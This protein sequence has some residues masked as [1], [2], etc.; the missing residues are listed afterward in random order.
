M[1]TQVKGVVA[2]FL[3][4]SSVRTAQRAE[5]SKSTK[6]TYLSVVRSFHRHTGGKPASA[7]EPGDVEG[8]MLHLAQERYSRSS[9]KQALCALVYVFRHVLGRD[10]GTL[11]LP[12]MPK[13]RRPAKI[14]PTRDELRVLFSHL[15]G[16]VRTMCGVMYG[17]GLRVGEC[18]QLRVK[19][20]DFS[21]LTIRVHEGK[22]DK[23]RLCLLPVALAPALQRQIEWRAAMHAQDVAEGAGWVELPGRLAKK[24]PAAPR[25]LRWQFLFPSAVLRGGH[26]WHATPEAVQKALRAAVLRAGILKL[27]TPHT[28]R[29]AFCTHALRAGNDAATVQELMG[30]DSLE[31]TMTYAHGDHARGVSPLDAA[32]VVPLMTYAHGDH[33]RGV[34]P[35]D[36]ADVVPLMTPMLR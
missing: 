29:H 13:E 31:T 12:A 18:C 24:Y 10:L 28:L 23:D 25:D 14:I 3:E 19:D 5:L 4:V 11:D 26:R 33:A 20:V 16:M 22:G 27:I 8:F 34:S 30:H 15:K 1:S 21:A 9:R 2:R 35:L 32:D 6:R 7:W 36:A 17:A